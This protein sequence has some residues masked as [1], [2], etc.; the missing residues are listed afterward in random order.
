M[1][2]RIG[3]C[4]LACCCTALAACTAAAPKGPDTSVSTPAVGRPPTPQSA[5]AAFSSEAFTSYAELS[6]ASDDG[7]AP[8]ESDLALHAA[9][10]NDAGYSQYANSTPTETLE[11]AAGLTFQQ[12]FGPWGYIGTAEAAQYGFNY[13]SPPGPGPLPNPSNPFAGLSAGAQAAAGKC[14]NI[15]WNFSN[16]QVASS[17]A[18]IDTMSNAISTDLAQN[19]DVKNATKAWSTCVARNGYTAPD[20]STLAFHELYALGLTLGSLRSGHTPGSVTPAQNKAQITAAVTD[21]DCTLSTD[22]A[23]IYFAVQASYE[24][25]VVTANQQALGAAVRQYRANYAKEL[26][27]LPALLR[28][29][30]ATPNL[31]GPKPGHPPHSGRAGRAS[32]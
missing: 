2:I 24:R 29:T 32:G 12:P 27:E 17:L 16:S 26:G 11:S 6:G 4:L 5:Q 30:S 14:L 3:P 8:G 1:R 18:G 7:L 28:T 15:V 19:P 22:L 20:A 21:A 31:P 9:C 25:Q 10:M 23:G 13:M